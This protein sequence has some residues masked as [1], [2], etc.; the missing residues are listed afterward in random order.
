MPPA[1]PPSPREYVPPRRILLVRLSALGDVVHSLSALELARR[2]WPQAELWW[3]VERLA[4]PLLE[5]H[6]ALTGVVVLERKQ[7]LRSPRALARS[8]AGMRQ[9]RRLRC[10]AALDLQGLLRSASVARA[11][12]AKRVFGPAWAR[13]G[14]GLLYS[15]GLAAPRPGEAHAVD[16]Y[17]A[18]IAAAAGALGQALPPAAADLPRLPP[19]LARVRSLAPRLVLLPGAGKQANRLPPTLLAAVADACAAEVPGLEVVAL[20]GPSDAERASA[21]AQAA[22]LAAIAVRCELDLVSSAL[23]LGSAWGVLGGDTGPLHLARALGVPVLGVF[24]AADPARTGPGGV[25]GPG[26]S[27][28]LGGEVSCAPCLARRCLRPDR[29]RVCLEGAQFQA[30]ALAARLLE[31]LRG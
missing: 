25:P 18:L 19:A 3:A 7:A 10:D 28:A 26:W 14:A 11:S 17:R 5:G 30:P 21:V 9:L 6:P 27:L 2:V 24:H 23:L 22:Q 12:G 20:G 4:A 1:A 8:L 29:V 16:R 15:Q 13:E 31:H